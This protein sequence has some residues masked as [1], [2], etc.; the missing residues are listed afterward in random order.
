VLSH[1]EKLEVSRIARKLQFKGGAF[2]DAMGPKE[3][4]QLS[5]IV[6]FSLEF[7]SLTENPLNPETLS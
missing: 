6:V 3:S 4:L 5:T 2:E 1:Q 7:D